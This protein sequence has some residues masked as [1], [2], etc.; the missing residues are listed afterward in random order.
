[1]CAASIPFVVV[2][3]ADVAQRGSQRVVAL[4]APRAAFPA[5]P[6]RLTPIVAIEREEF[7][8]LVNA[9][10]TVSVCGLIGA[11]ASLAGRRDDIVAAIDYL[12]FGV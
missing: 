10:E 11:V 5:I 9:L 12:F 4:A 2:L 3:Q 7:V 8:L 1:M 6:G